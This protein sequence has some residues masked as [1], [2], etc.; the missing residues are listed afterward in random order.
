MD[1]TK[2]IALVAGAAALYYFFFK[3][4]ATTTIPPGTTVGGLTNS[5]GANMYVNAAGQVLNGAN[6]LL[7]TIKNWTAP[8][9]T[10]TPAGATVS[11]TGSGEGFVPN[12]PNPDP[13]GNFI[14]TSDTTGN[15]EVAPTDTGGGTQTI[16]TDPGTSFFNNSDIL[17]LNGPR[18]RRMSRAGL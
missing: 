17:S 14:L 6:T 16:V 3:G 5:T 1:S 7:G 9:T 2:T 18:R 8:T 15:T 10:T 4:G 12:T 13:A 11:T